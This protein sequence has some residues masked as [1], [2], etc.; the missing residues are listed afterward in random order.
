MLNKRFHGHAT[1]SY[2]LL[3]TRAV[4]V[5]AYR[6]IQYKVRLR[7]SGQATDVSKVTST[8]NKEPCREERIHL[9]CAGGVEYFHCS[10]A[11]RRRRRKGKP[12]FSDNK[13]WSRVP[14]DSD[15]RMTA[16]ARASSNINDRPVL[17]SERAHHINK[18]AT[19]L[20]VIKI[21]S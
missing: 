4:Q 13:K 2:T 10:P 15:P 18:T 9:P 5:D 1:G 3:K 6:L 14:R 12:L 11:S 19:V 21:W 16:L 20:T 7:V 8:L 17:S